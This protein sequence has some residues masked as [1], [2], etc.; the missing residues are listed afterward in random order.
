MHNPV[1]LQL[2]EKH[3]ASLKVNNQ[4]KEAINGIKRILSRRYD[5]NFL[6]TV[7]KNKSNTFFGMSIY[8]TESVMDALLDQMIN[9]KSRSEALEK[10]WAEQK[11]WVLEIDDLLLNDINLNTNPKE[12]VAILLHEIG[13]VVFSNTVI[14]RVNKVLRYELMKTAVKTKKI[15]RWQRARRIFQLIFIDAC[16]SKNYHMKHELEADKFV[17][18]EGYGE[19]LETFI[20][21]LLKTQGNSL[22]DRSEKDMEKDI[23]TIVTWTF[24]TVGELE[25]RK[26]KLRS[27]LQAELLIN[28]SKYVRSIVHKVKTDFF[29]GDTINV[30]EEAALEQ[31]IMHNY[32]YT[33]KEGFFGMFDKF[34]KLKKL[35]QSDIDI[36]E[37]EMSRV[38]TQDD[39][40]YVLDL[41]Y[42]NLDIINTALEM[43]AKKQADKVPLSKDTLKRFKDQ[44]DKQRKQLLSMQ[45]K[46][47]SYGIFVRYPKGYEG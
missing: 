8:P 40:I 35:T 15:I 30:Y 11:E 42:D 16:G 9:N 44:L 10:I 34:G 4:D 22:I 3:M 19:Q 2:L 12:L 6:I 5:V 26:T 43:I 20:V 31:S 32:N 38:Q 47:P 27:L 23:R 33:L 24:V 1:D 41:I 13:H 7:V 46:D 18:K 17:V 36:I 29:G 21:K 45:I 25:F 37:I 39:K 14:Q 28:P